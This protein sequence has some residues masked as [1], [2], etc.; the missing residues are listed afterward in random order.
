MIDTSLHI[1]KK[2]VHS[3]N[4]MSKLVPVNVENNVESLADMSAAKLATADEGFMTCCM[5]FC[6]CGL[7]NTTCKCI[8]YTIA[9]SVD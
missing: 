4:K 3:S 9:T 6:V 1:F 7:V 5:T 2:G 8:L